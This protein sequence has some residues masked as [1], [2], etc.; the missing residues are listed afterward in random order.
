VSTSFA[1]AW[2]KLGVSVPF[3]VEERSGTITVVDS[4][5]NYNRQ[6]YDFEAVVTNEREMSLVTN[7]T[8]HIVDPKDQTTILMK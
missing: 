5:E 4:L 7:V 6:N 8:I 3:A 2:S 1:K